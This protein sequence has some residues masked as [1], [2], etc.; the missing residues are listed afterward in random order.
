MTLKL[1]FMG[2]PDFAV[3]ALEEIIKRYDVKAVFTQPD[4][5]KG[6]GQKLQYNPV[7]ETALLSNIPVYQPKR[8][9]GDEESKAIIKNINPDLIIVIA[10]GQILPKDILEIPRLGCVNLHASLL[11]VL[12]GAAP[13][14]WSIINGD[15]KSGNTTMLMAEGLDTG[16]MLLKSEVIIGENETAEELHDR[17]SKNGV[18]L[19]I[20][21]IE[22][23]KN[24]SIRPEKQI[25]E[26]SSYA[27]MLNKELG[28][29]NW[30]NSC[31]K[32]HC[33]IRG[34]TSWPGA[35][36]FFENKMIKLCKVE[37]NSNK[38]IHENVG[39]I[40]GTT[41]FGIE[42]SCRE[43]SIIIKELQEVGGKRMDSAAYLN[44]H[45]LKKG[46]KLV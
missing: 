14:N 40:L 22:G 35:Y 8:L 34:V 15:T 16:D 23:L 26:L 31:E 24:N 28:H 39:E 38:E 30:D 45:N 17:L 20:N 42:V 7:K 9:R 37:K 36:S 19:L 33:L 4:K 32:I 46:D 27:P 44:G 18:L 12:R 25:D 10:F 21:T 6:R 11:P 43:G 41:K 29:I 13:I 1:V 5:P 3:P 2:T